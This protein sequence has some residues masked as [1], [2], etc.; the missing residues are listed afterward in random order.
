MDDLPNDLLRHILLFLRLDEIRQCFRVCHKWRQVTEHHYFWLTICKRFGFTSQDFEQMTWQDVRSFFQ[1]FLSNGMNFVKNFD[2]VDVDKIHYVVSK[3]RRDVYYKRSFKDGPVLREVVFRTPFMTDFLFDTNFHMRHEPQRVFLQGFI[4]N[5]QFFYF[6][7]QLSSKSEVCD[8]QD[9][10]M[11]TAMNMFYAYPDDTWVEVTS[12]DQQTH[13]I[14]AIDKNRIN[15][16]NDSLEIYSGGHMIVH[17][18]R[19]SKGHMNFKLLRLEL[20]N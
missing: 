8:Y 13:K 1:R 17:F 12:F 6:V 3:N 11:M 20:C 16:L 19:V 18:D 14:W 4:S 7:A 10:S 15:D 2:Q 5:K 9:V